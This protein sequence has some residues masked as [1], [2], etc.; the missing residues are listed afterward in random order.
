MFQGGTRYLP[1][2]L[3]RKR[4]QYLL[5]GT[6]ALHSFSSHKDPAVSKGQIL[7]NAAAQFCKDFASLLIHS[8]Q[9]RKSIVIN[10]ICSLPLRPMVG[11]MAPF[12]LSTNVAKCKAMLAG[13]HN[14]HFVAGSSYEATNTSVPSCKDRM[15]FNNSF[16]SGGDKEL[17]NEPSRKSQHRDSSK[18]SQVHGYCHVC[19]IV[20][21]W[22]RKK[23]RNTAFGVHCS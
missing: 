23:N 1:E 2:F 18:V 13:L 16:T 21:W 20:L 11:Y 7:S 15:N 8:E 9:K 14:T 19:A 22:D 6:L 12:M 3:E 5:K 4:T 10:H 17:A